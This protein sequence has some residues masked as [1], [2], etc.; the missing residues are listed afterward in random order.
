MGWYLL[1]YF[2]AMI[3]VNELSVGYDRRAVAMPINGRFAMGSLTAIIGANGAG[4]STFLKTLAGLQAPVAGKVSF[5]DTGCDGKRPRLAYLPQQAELDRAFPIS[6]FDLVAMGCWPQSGLFGGI[7]RRSV[8][9]VTEA[10]ETVGMSDMAHWPVGELSGGQLQ[11]TLFARLLIQ[12]AP[13]IMLDEPFTGIDSQT[14]ELLL[15]VIALWH[16]EGKTVIAVLHDIS[17][18]A[19]HFP[20]VLYLSAERNIWGTTDDVLNN[21]PNRTHACVSTETFSLAAGVTAS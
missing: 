18:V 21:F 20:Q 9:Q 5:E 19:R 12:Q 13:L 3:S 4:K 10:L 14:I 6:V 7:S 15:K 1:G 8:V 17:M 11:R 2:I 16:R